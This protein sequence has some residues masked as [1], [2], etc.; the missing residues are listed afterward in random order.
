MGEQFKAHDMR[1]IDRVYKHVYIQNVLVCRFQG[2]YRQYKSGKLGVSRW[3]GVY[4][5]YSGPCV[6]VRIFVFMN[7][8]G[9]IMGMRAHTLSLL[10]PSF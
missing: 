4:R 8:S 7:V 3:M 10:L 2:F 9:C 6:C 5:Q 1:E